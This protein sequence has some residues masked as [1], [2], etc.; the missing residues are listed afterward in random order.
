MST[1]LSDKDIAQF[2][3]E[4]Y[5][6]LENVFSEATA[7]EA[8]N[9]LWKDA[10]CDPNDASTWTKPVVRLGDYAQEPFRKAVNNEMLHTAFNQLVGKGRWLPRNSLGTFPVRF[11][12]NE[13]PNDTG[14]HV[15]ASFPGDDP[16]DYFSW[17]IN[18][19][20]KGRVLLMLF[21][22]SEI[23]KD[24]APTRIKPGSHISVAKILQ[25]YGDKGLSFL[26][27]AQKLN[28]TASVYDVLAT[29]KPGTVYLCHPFLVHAAQPHHGK[30]VRF[31]AQPP[32]LPVADLQP[33]RSDGN[34]SPMETAIRKGLE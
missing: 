22:F 1:V 15:E 14:W 16:Q 25:P 5:V 3:N 17:R 32:L 12:S 8:R 21:L 10:G 13:E 27:L 19:H 9:I 4:G 31:M 33:E 30:N 11:P 6:K 34:Y 18:V 26:E 23:T 20:S 24:D 28:A 7:E 2:I 29:G